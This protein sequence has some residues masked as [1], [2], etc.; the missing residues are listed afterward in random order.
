MTKYISPEG[1][2]EPWYDDRRDYNTNAP[3]YF[4]YLAN[5]NKLTKEIVNVVNEELSRDVDFLD[6][7]EIHVDK[8]TDWHDD[9][10]EHENKTT[11]KAHVI[12]S[13]KTLTYSLDNVDYQAGNALKVLDSG[14]Y[15][16]DF[17]QVI[18]QQTTRLN[19]ASTTAKRAETK[20]DNAQKTADNAQ[21]TADGAKILANSIN[22]TKQ[23]KLTAGNGITIKDNVINATPLKAGHG[24]DISD[25]T[26]S[27]TIVSTAAPLPEQYTYL[28]FSNVLTRG[29]WG[30]QF[31]NDTDNKIY[32]V[33][34]KVD[35]I[36]NAG[37]NSV[38]A[39]QSKSVLID[40]GVPVDFLEKA[41]NEYVF[42]IGYFIGD[43]FNRI[44]ISI[45]TVGDNVQL[46]YKYSDVQGNIVNQK[47]VEDFATPPMLISYT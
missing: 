16:P 30:F 34:L 7:D 24:I 45:K 33:K 31:V 11:F 10:A 28:N 38:I 2:W 37:T 36:S 26:I 3:T 19:E 4:D 15:T 9:D 29:D 1:H 18:S 27:T 13:P 44:A 5:K 14:L 25:N 6:S 39:I 35:T 41:K 23:D 40:H 43:T 8:L 46:I 12:V 22:N 20:A 32:Y 21:K 17:S 47:I 42:R